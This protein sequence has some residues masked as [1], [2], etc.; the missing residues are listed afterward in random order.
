[1]CLFIYYMYSNKIF[2]SDIVCFYRKRNL[3]LCLS[4]ACEKHD[5]VV[6][7]KFLG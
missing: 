4:E 6:M 7:L 2:R 3:V 1:M 5:F